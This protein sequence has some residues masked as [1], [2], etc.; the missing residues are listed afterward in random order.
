[1]TGFIKRERKL[2]G[3][4]F[5]KT[6]ICGF[7]QNPDVTVEGIARNGFDH[8]LNIS[9]QGFDKMFTPEAA[10][11][12]KSVLDEAAKEAITASTQVDIEIFSRFSGV[13]IADCSI[14]TLPDELENLW[15]GVGGPENASKSAVKLDARLEL[16]SGLLQIGLLNGRAADNKSPGSEAVYA[17][18]S[19]RL[20]DL[21][22]FNLAR[23]KGQSER[24]EY[25]VSRLQPGTAVF[26]EEQISIGLGGLCRDLNHKGI[27]KHEINVLLGVKDHVPARLLLWR[28]PQEMAS[29]R[30][31]KLKE[32]AAKK[33][34][35]PSQMQMN[36]C[37]WNFLVANVPVAK[38]SLDECFLLYSVRWQ[39]ELLFKLWKSH[40]FLGVSRSKNPYRILCEVYTK[41]LIALI[42]HWF[43]LTGCWQNPFRSL[44]KASQVVKAQGSRF[45][46]CLKDLN[47]LIDFLEE[48]A[49]RFQRGCSVNK[50]KK[51]PSSAQKLIDL[52]NVF[53]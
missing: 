34:R 27:I 32:K 50:R 43:F 16:K 30:R 10:V 14:V 25:W 51:K 36:L 47:L 28:M 29:Q 11:F 48:L 9:A 42:Q 19:L 33:G 20:Q 3:S 13:Y 12:V 40:V 44:V 21:G 15:Q 8:E 38:L 24:G 2:L 49:K 26:N 39:I 17:A 18:G 6:L 37:D 41:L 35:A 22:C 53:S 5:I 7:M 45:A 46:S 31:A 23:M 4:K 52:K 1:V